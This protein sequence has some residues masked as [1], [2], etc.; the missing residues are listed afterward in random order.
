MGCYTSS[1][2]LEN[3]PTMMSA[4]YPT[5][6]DDNSEFSILT[7]QG[8]ERGEIRAL[9]SASL[10]DPPLKLQVDSHN[11]SE[12]QGIFPLSSPHPQTPSRDHRSPND[13]FSVNLDSPKISN[14]KVDQFT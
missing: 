14:V 4:N 10:R 1:P 3:Q 6:H 2:K 11:S 8:T 13:S 9:S 12:V 7:Q 5:L